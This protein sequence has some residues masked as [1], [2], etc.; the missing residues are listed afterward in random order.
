MTKA[1]TYPRRGL[2]GVVVHDIGLRIVQGELRPGE[3]LPTEDELSG[4][5]SVSRTVLREAVKV[6]AAKRLVES[7]P[8]TG[9]RVQ[10]R[11]E[12]NL[13]DPDVLAW[14]LEAGPDRRFLEDTLEL[15]ALIEPAAARLAAERANEGEI[16]VLEATCGEMLQVGEDLNAWIEP[17]LRFHSV[18]LQAS[19]NELLEH[20][21]EIVGSVLRT[22]FTFSSRPSGSFA[23]AA[24]L[25]LAIVEAINR[26]D[27][28][29]AEA[30]V[31]ELLADT[32]QNL[33]RALQEG[34][35]LEH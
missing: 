3:P 11:R 1:R 7:R 25:H 8:K 4:E 14:Q 19:H 10:P 16:S 33:K 17:D 31:L 15:R 13:L 29:A 6:L 9:T 32:A 34:E 21:T 22:L 18:L 28:D 5:L 24:P 20:L 23:R 26:R 2:H 27:P 12:W 35:G 30:A